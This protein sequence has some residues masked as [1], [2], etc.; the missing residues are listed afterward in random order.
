MTS[1]APTT[2]VRGLSPA[3]R[4]TV[5]VP[6][7]VGLEG[8]YAIDPKSVPSL[9]SIDLDGRV[10]TSDVGRA[11]HFASHVECGAWCR[12]VPTALNEYT[13]REVAVPSTRPL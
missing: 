12:T 3:H 2:Y 8:W 9:L 10:T 5:W 6:A 13:P 1:V 7:L 11:R 4:A